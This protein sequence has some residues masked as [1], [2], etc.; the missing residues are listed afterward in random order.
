MLPLSFDLRRCLPVRFRSARPAEGGDG[1]RAFL[2]R[3]G[4]LIDFVLGVAF[5]RSNTPTAVKA[6][7]VRSRLS[8]LGHPGPSIPSHTVPALRL[9]PHSAT[10]SAELRGK[11]PPAVW[12]AVAWLDTNMA[13]ACRATVRAEKR[14]ARAE[15]VKAA[16]AAGGGA[17]GGG[18][19]GS[20]ADALLPM[21]GER[22]RKSTV[23]YEPKLGSASG[24]S[25]KTVD[26]KKK[27]A[28]AKVT[29]L[30]AERKQREETRRLLLGKLWAELEQPAEGAG[31]VG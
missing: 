20:S 7:C 31:L 2:Q 23:R 6:W 10:G 11:R 18:A 13:S 17:A 27:T 4:P 25:R 3:A 28:M 26:T 29:A 30:R 24:R 22:Q 1:T 14:R 16:Q 8:S 15:A 5:Y 21:D 12:E 19:A 9:G